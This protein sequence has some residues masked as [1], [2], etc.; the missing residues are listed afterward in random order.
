MIA[1]A[2]WN[3]RQSAITRGVLYRSLITLK[4]P[5]QNPVP[6]KI[7]FFVLCANVTRT[8]Q[9][10]IKCRT[11]GTEDEI[12]GENDESK[13][14]IISLDSVTV[15]RR[16][17][18]PRFARLAVSEGSNPSPRTILKHTNALRWILLQVAIL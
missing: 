6:K 11:G 18:Y 9:R 17:L 3:Q 12:V 1:F 14:Q 15:A 13:I 4:V 16:D 10:N 7:G 8:G 5:I 2:Q